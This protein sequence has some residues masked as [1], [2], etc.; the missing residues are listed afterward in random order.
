MA[1]RTGL[2]P[3]SD[4]FGERGFTLSYRRIEI[5]GAGE[6]RTPDIQTASLTFYC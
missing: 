1:R 2:A 5:G 4:A 6:S 3:V